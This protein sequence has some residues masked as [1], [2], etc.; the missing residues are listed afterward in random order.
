MELKTLH[1]W[2]LKYQLRALPGVSEL[3]TWG[4]FTQQYH[5]I[6][7]PVR[8]RSYTLS[9]RDV[10]ESLRENNENFGGGFIEHASEQFTVRGLGRT[11][12]VVELNQIVLTSHDGTPVYLRDH[13]CPKQVS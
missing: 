5:V 8:L 13:S 11:R 7:D 4:G 3:N 6:V 12:S 10:F 1:D 9:L 2:E